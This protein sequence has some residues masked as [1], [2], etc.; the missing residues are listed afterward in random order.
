MTFPNETL[1]K[2]RLQKTTSIYD[3]LTQKGAVWQ[4][5]FGLENVL[6]F[7]N[8]PDDA[9]EEPTFHRSRSHEYVA[10]EV[11][12]VRA[13]VG[14]SEVANFA[15]HKFTGKG[16]KAFLN[17]VLAGRIPSPGRVNLTPMLLESG[18][19]NG[20]LTVACI[21]DETYYLFGSSV[22][23]NM[24]LRWFEMHL[25]G[26]QDVVYQNMTDDF[27]GIAISGPNSRELLSRLTR[28]D[29]SSDAFK[30]RDIRDTFVGG[31]PALCVRISFTGELGYEIY[32]APQYQLKLFEA[33]EE[34]GEDLDLKWFGGRALMSM[35]LE[36]SWGAWTMDFRPDFT[37]MESGLDFFVDWDKDFIGKKAALIE[38]MKG[39]TK[40]LSVIQIETET[41]VS[42]DEAVMHNGECVS[43]ITSGGYGHSVQRSLAMTYLPVE[44]IDSNTTLEVEILGEFHKASIVMEPLYDPSGSKMR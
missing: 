4:D 12:A 18:K 7:A 19:L 14:A 36:K 9:Y 15:N 1:P 17:K 11:E 41:D 20:D 42:G 37:I 22:A 29:V 24:H 26:I 8:S 3:R 44:L 40:K 43:Y 31:V 38:K 2:G 6:W 21:D 35:R 16:A 10:K 28:E 34:V 32:V 13:S 30:F 25:E 5:T 39:P 33:I 27:H 23:Q